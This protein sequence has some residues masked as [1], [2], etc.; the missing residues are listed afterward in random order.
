MV[1]TVAVPGHEVRVLARSERDLALA[2]SAGAARAIVTVAGCLGCVAIDPAAWTAQRPAL[3]ALWAPAAD[4]EPAVP[5]AALTITTIAL[6][7]AAAIA[8]DARRGAGAGATYVGHWNDGVTQVQAICE[9]ATLAA[10]APSPCAPV[11][12]AKRAGA[13]PPG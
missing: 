7:G 12:A 5:G 2:V 9:V 8:I 4:A 6:G 13:P 1:A 11:V 10:E 3:V